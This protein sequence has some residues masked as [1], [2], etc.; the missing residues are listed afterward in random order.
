MSTLVNTLNALIARDL[1]VKPED[2][3]LDLIREWRE[4]HKCAYSAVHPHGGHIVEGLRVLE[5]DEEL[6]A[7]EDADEIAVESGDCQVR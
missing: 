4:K 5:P 7:L 1:R 3:T 6:E 2:V